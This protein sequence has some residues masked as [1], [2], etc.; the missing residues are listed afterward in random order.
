MKLLKECS[1]RVFIGREAGYWCNKHKTYVTGLLCGV[2][3]QPE[4]DKTNEET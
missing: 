2:C 4:H 3:R 1:D